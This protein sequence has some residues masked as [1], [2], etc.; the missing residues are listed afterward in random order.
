MTKNCNIDMFDLCTIISNLLDNA[1]EAVVKVDEDSR[2]IDVTFRYDDL[3]LYFDVCN[4]Y[5]GELHISQNVI[6]TKKVSQNHGYGLLNVRKSVELYNGSMDIKT[7]NNTFEVLI[8][9][10]N[11]NKQ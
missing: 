3:M 11:K 5:A 6:V 2:Y 9:L 7:D 10:V 8:A 4:P 1:I